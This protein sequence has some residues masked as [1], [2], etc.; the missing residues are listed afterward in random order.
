MKEPPKMKLS[1]IQKQVD[2][3]LRSIKS[4]VGFDWLRRITIL[5][6]SKRDGGIMDCFFDEEDNIIS[7]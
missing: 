2:S 7:G 1:D 4:K 3:T 5:H 6:P